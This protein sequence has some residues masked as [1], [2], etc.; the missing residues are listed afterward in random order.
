MGHTIDILNLNRLLNQNIKSSKFSRDT[1]D[2]SYHMQ[3]Q[4]NKLNDCLFLPAQLSK[5]CINRV[6]QCYHTSQKLVCPA[7]NLGMVFS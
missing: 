1:H 2:S 4:Y 5:L 6:V 3:M 7:H